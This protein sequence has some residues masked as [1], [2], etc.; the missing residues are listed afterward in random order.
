MSE[1]VKKVWGEE[2]VIVNNPMYCGKLLKIRKGAKS[3]LHYHKEKHETFYVL[4]GG[5][6]LEMDH[7]SV[8]LYPA[9]SA[10]IAPDCAHRFEGLE[11]SVII[12]FSTHHSDD[13]VVRLE[14]SVAK[15]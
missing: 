3:S 13:D 9:Q 11:D 4:S 5:V 7:Y 8:N 15:S 12:E 10:V 14:A 2:E 6:T 1:T